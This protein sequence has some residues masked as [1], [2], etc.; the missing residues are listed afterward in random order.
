MQVRDFSYQIRPNI[1]LNSYLQKKPRQY[2][3]SIM[4]LASISD[5][6]SQFSRNKVLVVKFGRGPESKTPCPP[7][8]GPGTQVSGNGEYLRRLY[9]FVRGMS[10]NSPG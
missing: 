2:I 10:T 9:L 8:V 7:C 1:F 3:K 4:K 5:F 6:D